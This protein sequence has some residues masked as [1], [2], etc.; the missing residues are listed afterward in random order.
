MI[1]LAPHGD[2][3]PEL[4][5]QRVQDPTAHKKRLHGLRRYIEKNQEWKQ[6]AGK[7]GR[8]VTDSKA[9]VV[10]VVEGEGFIQWKVE[11]GGA[12]LTWYGHNLILYTDTE[13][14]K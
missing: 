7:G 14:G 12:G 2:S 6:R 9:G 11:V 10:T 3:D 13:I 1:E 8:H 4:T 5:R